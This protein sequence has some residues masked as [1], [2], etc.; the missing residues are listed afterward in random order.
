MTSLLDIYRNNGYLEGCNVPEEI[1]STYTFPVEGE[2]SISDPILREAIH[3][4]FKGRCQNT[5]TPIGHEDMVIDHIIPSSKGGPDNIFNYALTAQRPNSL[6][7]DYLDVN[8]VLGVL[9]AVRKRAEKVLQLYL[10]KK[11]MKKR[12]VLTPEE[13]AKRER[14]KE[15]KRKDRERR[16]KIKEGK[17]LAID[18]RVREKYLSKLAEKV[19][20]EMEEE[21]TSLIEL[22]NCPF[23]PDGSMILCRYN[24][25]DG[26]VDATAILA[27]MI[28]DGDF[29]DLSVA[30]ISCYRSLKKNDIFLPFHLLIDSW[31]YKIAKHFSRPIWISQTAIIR[32][33]SCYI[34]GFIY[35]PPEFSVD[36][37]SSYRCN[38]GGMIT[39]SHNPNAAMQT[40][41]GHIHLRLISKEDFAELQ[42]RVD[43]AMKLNRP[44]KAAGHSLS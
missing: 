37:S 27:K 11:Q 1:L 13:R 9:Y 23:F 33:D 21:N 28:V 24:G 39:T 3:Q 43:G 17:R 6:K 44:K 36:D 30:D 4:V 12:V 35:T 10:Q 34:G 20:E 14:I 41:D 38:D 2:V 40:I 42:K 16:R 26:K 7:G 29:G 8:A 19:Q 31:A 22:Q 5:G 15:E 18:Q 32:I 25:F